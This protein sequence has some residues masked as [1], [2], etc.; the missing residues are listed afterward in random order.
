MEGVLG[1]VIVAMVFFLA[2]ALM[3]KLGGQSVGYRGGITYKGGTLADP[4]TLDNIAIGARK[5]VDKKFKNKKEV[6]A[7]CDNELERALDPIYK[8]IAMIGSLCNR[9]YGL[10]MYILNPVATELL[11]NIGKDCNYEY[12][13]ILSSSEKEK[14]KELSIKLHRQ[15]NEI[16]TEIKA[17]YE[18]KLF[19]LNNPT[20]IATNNNSSEKN[21][22]S[23]LSNEIK[24]LS[25]LYTEGVITKAEF[26]AA[27]INY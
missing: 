4:D 17:K 21:D 25:K 11:R 2:I 6:E 1:F 27:K 9:N 24:N 18:R 22:N 10:G 7:E 5:L 15:K 23:S 26:E 14:L 3:S 16:T 19:K 20:S 13:E 12:N 8:K